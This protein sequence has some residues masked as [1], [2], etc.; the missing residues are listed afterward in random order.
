M[1]IIVC[2]SVG[3]GGIEDIIEIQNLLRK[4]GFQV[5]N[6][7]TE[8]KMNYA[9]IDDFRDEKELSQEIVKHDLEHIKKSDVIVVLAERPSF[10]TAI[11]MYFA[12]NEKKKIYLLA[13][14][15]IPTPWPIF[16]A[17]FVVKTKENLIKLLK[18]NWK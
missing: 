4:N 10:G 3:F 12:K 13:T 5:I 2:G 15:K 7:F 18:E 1:Q 11:E 8:K 6:Q 17:D 9:H 14:E 16:F